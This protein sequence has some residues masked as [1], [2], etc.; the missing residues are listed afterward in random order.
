MLDGF[1][2]LRLPSQPF[3]LEYVDWS[4]LRSWSWGFLENSHRAPGTDLVRKG[5]QNVGIPLFHR[6]TME[7][8]LG[9]SWR[10]EQVG[11]GQSPAQKGKASVVV[12]SWLHSALWYFV[13]VCYIAIE[14]MALIEIVVLP[15]LKMAMFHNWLCIQVWPVPENG[16][17]GY[18]LGSGR[19]YRPW[20]RQ[21][22][23]STCEVFHLELPNLSKVYLCQAY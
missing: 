10:C 8:T 18:H 4:Q 23:P 2:P 19:A 11:A 9:R 1:N 22:T 20:W 5:R 12:K 16:C 3:H 17:Q 15:N 13:T 6:K 14:A 7:K 21:P